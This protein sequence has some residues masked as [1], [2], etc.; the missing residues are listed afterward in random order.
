MSK[1]KRKTITLMRKETK[2]AKVFNVCERIILLLRYVL[3]SRH[4]RKKVQR[5][6][7]KCHTQI[8]LIDEQS[9]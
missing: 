5:F 8:I 3:M 2:E 9:I 6:I 1:R 7:I 4:T